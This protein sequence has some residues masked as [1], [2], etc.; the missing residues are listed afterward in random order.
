MSVYHEVQVRLDPDQLEEYP[1]GIRVQEIE[2]VLGDDPDR[3]SWKALE[4]ATCPI[5]ARRARTLALNLLHA[6]ETAELW[7]K[8]R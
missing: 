8:T 5:D 6:A 3:P 1:N 2:L 7:E 4:P